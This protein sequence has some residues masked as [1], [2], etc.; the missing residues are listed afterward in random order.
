MNDNKIKEMNDLYNKLEWE[1][2]LRKQLI[3]DY[4]HLT[5]NI[6]LSNGDKFVLSEQSLKA[7]KE[8]VRTNQENNKSRIKEL[9]QQLE[10]ELKIY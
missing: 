3:D 8:Q 9:C 4:H 1:L 2:Q 6:S 7:L 10:K 5:R